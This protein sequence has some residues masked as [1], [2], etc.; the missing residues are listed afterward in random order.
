MRKAVSVMVIS[1]LIGSGAVWAAPTLVVEPTVFDIGR[2]AENKGEYPFKFTVK[3]EGDEE[4]Q[5]SRVR[6]GCSC[7]K[8]ELKKQNLAPGEV[9]E[10]TGTLSTKGIE[11]AMQKGIILTSNDPVRQTTVASVAVRFPINGQGL[12]LKGDPTSARVRQGALWAY[13]VVENCEPATAVK[14]EAMELPQGWDCQQP[15]PITVPPEEHA[16]LVLTR[17]VGETTEPEPFEGLPFTLVTDSAKTPRVQGSLAFR[18]EARAP[19][20]STPA[21]EAGAKARWPMAK[22]APQGPAPIT[23]PLPMPAPGGAALPPGGVPPAA[24]PAA[25]AP[26]A[27]PAAAPAAPAPVAPPAAA[28]AAPTPAAPAP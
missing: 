9:T 15:L 1:G 22:P 23:A 4:L 2:Q 8:V 5:I 21:G 17:Q 24:A 16:S 10:M 6:P 28:P 26:V 7:T 11:G 3:N 13:V 14:I 12:R 19:V 27:P 18:P 20:V 25:P